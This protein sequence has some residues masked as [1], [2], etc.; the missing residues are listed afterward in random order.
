MKATTAR[1][2]V[3]AGWV[4]ELK[5]DGMRA[6]VRVG[7]GES[8]SA[9]I[10]DGNS[11]GT[12][13]GPDDDDGAGPPVRLWSANGIEA[14]VTYPELAALA[15]AFA[16]LEVVVDGEIVALDD[17]GIP[18]FERL[19]QRMHISSPVEAAERAAEVPVALVLFDLL[20][21]NG[22]STLDLPW[23]DRRNLLESLSDDLPPGVR[24]AGTFTDGPALFDAAARQGM[25]GV[26]AKRVDSP[27]RP[28]KRTTDWVKVKVQRRQ[29]VVIG[30]WALGKGERAGTLGA[31]LVGYY[32]GDG[33]LHYAGRVGTGFTSAVLDEMRARLR[34]LAT[35]V[36]PFDPAPPR[37]RTRDASWVRP[38]L[39]AEV[40]F[41]NWTGEGI[42][43][44]PV[45]LGLR[46]DKD[47]L[48]V[49]REP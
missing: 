40:G 21:V 12:A 47:P 23:R 22:R 36:C 10:G 38:E 43:R 9:T 29:E 26:I 34:P 44:H 6:V 28:G 15:G 17:A 1:L 16:G 14:T 19:Q 33:R 49:V 3:G 2:P 48:D 42:M 31:L 24:L 45:Y 11:D 13:D 4:Y 18:S 46:A 37:D 39:V 8:T 20:E 41:G 35:P 5:W 7:V 32:D 27:Y 25:E 30:G